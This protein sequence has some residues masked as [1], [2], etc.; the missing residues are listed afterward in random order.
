[1]KVRIS[2]LIEIDDYKRVALA[3]HN[4][5]EPDKWRR[6]RATRAEIQEWYS[7]N[8]DVHDADL[9]YEYQKWN[10]DLSEDDE[11]GEND[12]ENDDQD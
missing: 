4:A 3:W 8:C 10:G 1:M 11:G 2:F 6:R 7:S 12:A 9:V 5:G